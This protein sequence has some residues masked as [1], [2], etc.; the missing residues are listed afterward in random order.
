MASVGGPATSPSPA[1]QAYATVTVK[2]SGSSTR[3]L[4]VGAVVLISGAVLLLFG[5]IGAF[6]FWK[7]NDNHVSSMSERL[8][9]RGCKGRQVR[10]VAEPLGGAS[11]LVGQGAQPAAPFGPL[12][13]LGHLPW[14]VLAQSGY[15]A[16]GRQ[17]QGSRNE[18]RNGDCSRTPCTPW[19]KSGSAIRA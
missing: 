6:Y 8:P 17:A 10:G 5:A 15:R 1:P 9:I 3:L 7:G 14:C 18:N 16:Q 19:G 2:P 11:A 13:S 12:G 4:K